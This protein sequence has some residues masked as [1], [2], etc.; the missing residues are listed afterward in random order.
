[1]RGGRGVTQL[2]NLC[3]QQLGLEGGRG[4]GLHSRRWLR[5]NQGTLDFGHGPI[6]VA[7]SVCRKELTMQRSQGGTIADRFEDLLIVLYLLSECLIAHERVPLLTAK[8]QKK[9]LAGADEC[10]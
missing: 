5:R 4:D 2:L 10:P 7:F 8:Q 1:M 3:V 9:R 6:E